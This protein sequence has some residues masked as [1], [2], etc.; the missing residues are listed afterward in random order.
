MLLNMGGRPA[1]AAAAGQPSSL[2]A[3]GS[4]R[5]APSWRASHDARVGRA[6]HPAIGR[7]PPPEILAKA[8]VIA[9]VSP[10]RGETTDLDDL[11]V[12]DP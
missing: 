1:P 3:A 11:A 7:P 5:S 6:V 8:A 4:A 12:I 10:E 9:T 2:T